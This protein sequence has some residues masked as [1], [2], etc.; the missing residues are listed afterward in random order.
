MMTYGPF[1]IHFLRPAPETTLFP[2]FPPIFPPFFPF[3]PPFFIYKPPIF[4]K[5]LVLPAEPAL[6]HS[7]LKTHYFLPITSI[8]HQKLSNPQKLPYPALLIPIPYS[9]SI[10]ISFPDTPFIK[11]TPRKPMKTPRNPHKPP[12]NPS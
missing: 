11:G 4:P 9:Y 2:V 8:F 12:V 3:L 10:H 6:S 7:H 1:F 5:N